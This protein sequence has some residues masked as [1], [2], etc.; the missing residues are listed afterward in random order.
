MG[1]NRVLYVIVKDYPQFIHSL[2]VKTQSNSS[3]W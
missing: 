2:S 3:L 1:N